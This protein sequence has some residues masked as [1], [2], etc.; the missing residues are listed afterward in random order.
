MRRILW[1]NG[2]FGAGKSTTAIHIA[3]ADPSW[4]LFDPEWVGYMLRANLHGHMPADFQDLPAWRTLVP[5]VAHE[6]ASATGSDL[7]AV[8][9]V[10]NEAYWRQIRS[11]M[12]SLGLGVFHVVLDV[13][14]TELRERIAADTA[15][16]DAAGWRLGHVDAWLSARGWMTSA[17][18][19]VVDASVQGAEEVS[20]AVLAALA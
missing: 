15:D 13:G 19:L 6:V 20:R 3:A 7:L 1:L 17:A 11:G 10:L 8:Q 9:T 12:S 18:D 16:A 2:A 4:H 5:R 14:E